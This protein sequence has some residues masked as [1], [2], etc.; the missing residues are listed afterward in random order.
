MPDCRVQNSDLVFVVDLS[1]SPGNS[2]GVQQLLRRI[3]RQVESPTTRLG[4]IGF[5][6]SAH[7]LYYLAGER[8]YTDIMA[9]V[10][11]MTFMQNSPREAHLGIQMMKDWFQQS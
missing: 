2:Q 8:S 3:I 4:L 5:N 1:Q 7:P 10:D 9:V 6:D 11:D